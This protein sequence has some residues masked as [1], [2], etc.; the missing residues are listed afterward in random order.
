MSGHAA[1]FRAAGSA[2][3]LAIAFAPV[4]W[5]APA[6]AV[7]GGILQ[8]C[9]N[10]A[11]NRYV[12]GTRFIVNAAWLHPLTV[13]ANIQT[14]NQAIGYTMPNVARGCKR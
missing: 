2:A 14:R 7:L 10:V 11:T 13:Y 3:G 9:E 4:P 1:V 8:M 12:F 6:A 5:L